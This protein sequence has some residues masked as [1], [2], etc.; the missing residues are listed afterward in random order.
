MSEKFPVEV[1]AMPSGG[2]RFV[3]P[4]G[5]GSEMIVDFDNEDFC[6]I[7]KFVFKVFEVEVP[8]RGQNWIARHEAKKEGQK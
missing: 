6:E 2:W 3:K 1:V 4:F 7:A 5:F 8:E